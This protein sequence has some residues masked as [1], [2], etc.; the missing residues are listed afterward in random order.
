MSLPP[1]PV[2]S[3]NS[4]DD[5][6]GNTNSGMQGVEQEVFVIDIVNVAIVRIR[7]SRWPRIYKF[8]PVSGVLESRTILNQDNP[9][10]TK[11]VFVAKVLAK[12]IIWNTRPALRTARSRSLGSRLP[13]I[14]LSIV[15]FVLGAPALFRGLS[16]L[17][18]LDVLLL[19]SSL[20]LLFT[21]S[22]RR[23]VLKLPLLFLPSTILIFRL[24]LFFLL[25]ASSCFSTRFCFSFGR[26]GFR[27][28]RLRLL[29]HRLSLFL[30]ILLCPHY[31]CGSE[32]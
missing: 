8:K 12:S 10:Y 15:I 29:R 21:L 32:K 4:S 26:L 6:N 11:S 13:S 16:L 17:L 25:W 24:T 30:L 14:V 2:T 20:L 23:L 5:N 18:L 19:L 22:V 31:D 7:P 28:T 27:F 3:L 9:F 1:M